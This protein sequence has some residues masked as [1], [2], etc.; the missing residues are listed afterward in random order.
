MSSSDNDQSEAEPTAPETEE[1]FDRFG[2]V[3]APPKKPNAS[4]GELIGL[5]IRTS[6]NSAKEVKKSTKDPDRAT[7]RMAALFFISV[8]LSIAFL[9]YG[10]YRHY[11]VRMKEFASRINEDPYL[12]H[13]GPQAAKPPSG[14]GSEG[15]SAS[16]SRHTSL[17]EEPSKN[18]LPTFTIG[19]FN[20]ELKGPKNGKRVRGLLQIVEMEL[21]VECDTKKTCAYIEQNIAPVR[22]EVTDVFTPIDREEILSREGKRRFLRE[23]IDKINNFLPDGKI[24]N[25]YIN[26]MVIS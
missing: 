18:G 17:D 12:K 6:I 8:S 15:D 3:V 13:K 26:K 21:V 4:V 14:H 19:K 24:E 1:K 2:N 22:G 23:V 5:A 10:V 25:I 7:R 16:E 11:E 9:V 20:I